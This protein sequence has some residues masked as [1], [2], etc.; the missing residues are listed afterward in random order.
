[1]TNKKREKK[2]TRRK[3]RRKISISSFKRSKRKLHFHLT[4]FPHCIQLLAELQR[5]SSER[6]INFSNGM[7]EREGERVSE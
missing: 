6:N 2:N 3:E 4:H 7:S 5:S 1:M